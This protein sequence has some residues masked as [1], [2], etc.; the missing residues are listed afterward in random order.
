MID[1]YVEHKKDFECK[2][3]RFTD[4]VLVPIHG[5]YKNDTTDSHTGNVVIDIYGGRD[6]SCLTTVF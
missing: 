1:D 6:V 5:K 3:M 4:N 2:P